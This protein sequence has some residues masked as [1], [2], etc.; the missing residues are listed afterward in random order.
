MLLAVDVGERPV[1]TI[2]GLAPADGLHPLQQAFI[3]AD[4]VQCGFCT[5]GML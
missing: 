1:T 3:D 4:A 5:S 2:E